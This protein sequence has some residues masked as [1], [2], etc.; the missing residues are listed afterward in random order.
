M[1]HEHDIGK[2][3]EMKMPTILKHLG[4]IGQ[5]GAWTIEVNYVQYEERLPQV[6]I[7]RWSPDHQKMGKGITLF[8]Q[9]FNELMRLNGVV[10]GNDS[11]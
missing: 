3:R 6:D 8:E 4:T 5:R 9:E 1:N 7:R 11:E 10:L 2:K